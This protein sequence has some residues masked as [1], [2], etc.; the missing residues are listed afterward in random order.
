VQ[1]AHLK[2]VI[3]IQKKNSLHINQVV[4]EGG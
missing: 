3:H 4:A 1:F 2:P